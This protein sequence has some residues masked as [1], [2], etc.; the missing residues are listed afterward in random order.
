MVPNST[1]SERVVGPITF[2]PGRLPKKFVLAVSPVQTTICGMLALVLVYIQVSPT[3]GFTGA[4]TEYAGLAPCHLIGP[5][6]V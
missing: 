4:V 3:T 1:I 5:L 2:H 6:V